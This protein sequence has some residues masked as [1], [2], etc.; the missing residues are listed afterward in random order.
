[1]IELIG[2]FGTAKVYNDNVD[3]ETQTQI[4]GIMNSDLGKNSRVRMMP[5][6]HAGA[7]GPI[8]LTMTI[9]DK[10]APS[11]VGSD[12]S[13]GIALFE[14][15]TGGQ[16]LDLEKFDQSVHKNLPAGY[17][18]NVIGDSSPESVL[19]NANVK[20]IDK[21]MESL[22][23]MKHISFGG[24]TRLINSAYTG[25][26]TLGG[27]NHFLEAYEKD[28][29]YFISVHTGSRSLGG[30]VY[31]YYN[32][33]AKNQSHVDYINQRDEITEQLKKEGRHKEIHETLSKLKAKFQKETNMDKSIR[34]LTGQIMEDYI[35]DVGI[36]NKY[37]AASRSTIV[38]NVINGYYDLVDHPVTTPEFTPVYSLISD[39]PHNYVEPSD[40]ILRKGAQ[41]SR[42][43][44]LIP[45]NMRDGML[46]GRFTGEDEEDWN[47]SAP[48][49]A[50]RKLSR[51]EARELLDLEEFKD[52]MKDVYSSTVGVSTLDEAP[53]AYKTISEIME[54]IEGSISVDY[55]LKPIYNF[56][57]G[58]ERPIWS[59][60]KQIDP[61]DFYDTSD[62]DEM[63]DLADEA[64]E[65][66][67][68]QKYEKKE[69]N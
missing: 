51:T 18:V 38:G 20:L 55:I 36:I 19:G 5:D 14:I 40:M 10:V 50:G 61:V 1:M 29:K 46:V 34:Y 59:K 6:T 28:G 4:I 30:Q 33:L 56:K 35:H 39:N 60:G 37:A 15:D 27:G 26:A 41:S 52:E 23:M 8:G 24:Q 22:K 47:Y 48:H 62:I 13:C 44:I 69:G 63:T 66:I 31:K 45:I 32:N 54:N 21:V 65:L 43:T 53:E 67:L 49:G 16:P 3:N 7:G 68:E 57:G 12:I 42:G 2:R 9:V 17:K 11:L 58:S 64:K 25:F